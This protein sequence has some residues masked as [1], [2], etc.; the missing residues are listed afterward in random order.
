[1]TVLESTRFKSRQNPPPPR[2]EK[3]R[4]APISPLAEPD[5]RISLNVS[6]SSTAPL[7]K[8][9]LFNAKFVP[10][11]GADSGEEYSLDEVIYRSQNGGLLDVE[12]DM[13]ALAIY[14]PEYWKAL[15]DE[16]VGKTVWPYGS[17][18]WSKKEWVLSLIH[19]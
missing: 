3:K 10:F 5:G 4:S 13:E 12:H 9:S 16:R 17:G 7:E 18:V 8:N 11:S 6:S 15:F 1:M 2:V 14:P 19:I